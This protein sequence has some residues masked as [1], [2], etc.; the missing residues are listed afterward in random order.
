MTGKILAR[1]QVDGPGFETYN[2]KFMDQI[3]D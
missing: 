1:G 2:F 3:N